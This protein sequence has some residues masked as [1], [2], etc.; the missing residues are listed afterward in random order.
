MSKKYA[1][2]AALVALI[3]TVQSQTTLTL[4]PNATA[5]KDAFISSNV[6]T[7]GQG[8][9]PELDAGAWTIS[10]SP[11][12]LRGLIDF[13]LSSLPT[14]AIVQSATLT[15][16]NNPSAVNGYANGQHVHVSGSNESV[17]QRIT[18]NW[19][20]DVAWNNQPTTTSQNE[21]TLPQD[22][23]PYQDYNLDVTN[24]ILDEIANPNSSFGF[25][26]KLKTESPY[27]ILVF[28]SSDHPNA[29]LH[30]KLVITY[31]LP[32]TT[33]ILQPNATAGKDA[34]ISSNVPSSGQG[35]SP[36]FDACAWTVFGTP[37]SIRGLIDFDLSSIPTTATIQSAT[38][39]LYN[40]P[41]AVNGYANGEHVH[42][43]GSNESVLQRITTPWNEDVAWNNQPTTTTQNEV[44]LLQDIDPFQDYSLDVKNLIQDDIA[45]PNSSYGFLLKL[46]TES[47]YRLLAFASSDHPNAA[48]HPKLEICY[49]TN[50]ATNNPVAT[51]IAVTVVPNPSNGFVTLNLE[52][53]SLSSPT[54]GTFQLFDATGKKVFEQK[55]N[56]N[57]NATFDF[58]SFQKGLYFWTLTNDQY[59]FNGKLILVR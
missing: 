10:G 1:L 20:E 47:P 24:L 57:T 59:R 35:T 48:L 26:L 15:L 37:I 14:G 4:Q 53:L 30:P 42:V 28:A 23:D 40:N 8:N 33:L 38:L 54:S 19:N 31:T 55:Q 22:I 58:S 21:V 50:L 6:P 18:S 41:N 11:L 5:G 44:T 3:S 52:Q 51:P 17:L 27:R 36:E 39:T 34:F 56:L 12:T 46:K 25:L 9:S 2:I 13:D 29:S 49:T 32:C 45:N 16:Y 43:S 7:T